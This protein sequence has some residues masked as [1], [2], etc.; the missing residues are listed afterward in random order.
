MV[1]IGKEGKL[2]PAARV[3]EE[4]EIS[5]ATFEVYEGGVVRLPQFLQRVTLLKFLVSTSRDDLH[6]S[7]TFLF[8][9]V[10]VLT[11]S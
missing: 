6:C 1:E 4:V 3:L 10:P 8:Y 11:A 5:R 7:S 9:N 2:G